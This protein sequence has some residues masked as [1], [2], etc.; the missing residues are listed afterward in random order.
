MPRY[1][2]R[3]NSL[4]ISQFPIRKVLRVPPARE[5]CTRCFPLMRSIA[6]RAGAGRGVRILIHGFGVFRD[7]LKLRCGRAHAFLNLLAGGGLAVPVT[8]HFEAL[9]ESLD[10]LLTLEALSLHAVRERELSGYILTHDAEYGSNP[11]CRGESF[12]ASKDKN[13]NR[14]EAYPRRVER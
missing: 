9:E 1:R 13:R 14:E 3:S 2:L 12:H 4:R 7:G 5:P 10:V 11:A 6:S 8:R